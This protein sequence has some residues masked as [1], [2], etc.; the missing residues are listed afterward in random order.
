MNAVGESLRFELMPSLW[1]AYWKILTSRKTG[2]VGN[3][4]CVPRLEA[5]LPS[6]SVSPSHL[7]RYRAVCGIESAS[8]LPIAYPHVLAM[9]LQLAVLTSAEF[10]VRI[11][12][13]VH[14]RH[15]ILQLRPIP[16]DA[17]GELRTWIQGYREARFGQ[18]FDLYTE[19]RLNHAPVWTELCTY[20]ARSRLRRDRTQAREARGANNTEHPQPGSARASR[21]RIDSR[22]A[23]RYAFVSGDFNPIHLSN[24]SSRLFGFDRAIM[25]GM[26]SLG[27]CAAALNESTLHRPCE[28]NVQF[29]A[30]VRLPADL[31]LYNWDIE[32]GEAFA[33]RC[34]EN[35]R[36][37]LTGSLT[38]SPR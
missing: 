26:W 8:F 9:P 25:H 2:V 30:P 14:I 11:L 23:R 28:L 32:A 3:G 13:F 6:A 15:S 21:F 33:L 16:N 1:S 7:A 36:A 20:L 5:V 37:H 10:P 4:A 12:G 35:Q 22:L 18:E 27:R 17:S 34:A 38:L 29:K 31:V 24:V 19:Y